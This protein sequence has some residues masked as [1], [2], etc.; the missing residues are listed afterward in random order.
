MYAK[1]WEKL[2]N[3]SSD[4]HRKPAIIDVEFLPWTEMLPENKTMTQ[5]TNIMKTA[6]ENTNK[7]AKRSETLNKTGSD[8]AN[9]KTPTVKIAAND[10][11]AKNEWNKTIDFGIGLNINYNAPNKIVKT[12]YF[13]SFNLSNHTIPTVANVEE[14]YGGGVIIHGLDHCKDYRFKVPGNKRWIAPAGLQNTG[15]N[16]MYKLLQRNCYI[17]ERLKNPSGNPFTPEI[18]AALDCFK[19]ECK[20]ILEIHD[21]NI[22][23]RE[24]VPWWKHAPVSWRDKPPYIL[25][26]GIRNSFLGEEYDRFNAL[27][28]VLIKDPLTWFSSMCRNQYEVKFPRLKNRCP[29]F[30]LRNSQRTPKSNVVIRPP[31][32]KRHKYVYRYK[33]LVD[34][35]NTYYQEWIDA[36]FPFLIARY[37]DLLFRPKEVVQKVCHCAGGKLRNDGF[38]HMQKS[39][40]NHGKGAG[41]AEN[42]MFTSAILYGTKEIRNF[43]LNEID[44][45]F[46]RRELDAQL[47][48]E[49]HYTMP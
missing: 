29:F 10:A 48:D 49:F 34:M 13:R 9:K 40:K 17:P 27:P 31:R 19:P 32:F 39:S 30:M 12:G 11:M 42:K 47:M 16:T 35:W 38:H 4:M 7:S 20:K 3:S 45:A 33:S 5:K 1:S 14:L 2:N 37:E 15:T 8:D 6:M 26:A 23:M 18:D 36:P 41:T 44:A 22:G 28:V 43:I 21:I 24:M 46:V 25:T